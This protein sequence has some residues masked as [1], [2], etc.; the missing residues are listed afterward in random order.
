MKQE[1]VEKSHDDWRGI[2]PTGMFAI[3][4]VLVLIVLTYQPQADVR[5]V[6]MMFPLSMTEEDILSRVGTNGGRVVRFGRFGN[7]AVVIRDDG[8][9][10]KADDFGALFS[11]NPFVLSV[12]TL[13]DGEQNIFL[14]MDTK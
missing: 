3:A 1:V 12:C 5:E 14:D 7:I 4:G 8:M 6:G 9:V 2:V 11:L 13:A 10:P